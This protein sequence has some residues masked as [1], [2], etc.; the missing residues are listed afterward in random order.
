MPVGEAV[1]VYVGMAVG[2]GVWVGVAVLAGKGVAVWVG[3]G[4]LVAVPVGV[5]PRADPGKTTRVI[6]DGG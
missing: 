3:T 2:D 4:E 1:T 5:E 6:E